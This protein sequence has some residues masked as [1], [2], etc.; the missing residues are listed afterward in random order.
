MSDDRAG[1][2]PVP[3][4]GLDPGSGW[5]VLDARDLRCPLPVI[6]VARLVRADASARGI[7]VWATDPAAAHDLPAWCRM[8]GH[9][10]AGSRAGGE[11]TAY[12][13][14]VVG[15]GG[16]DLSATEPAAAP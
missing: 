13:I 8:R 16:G 14:E 10:F 9:R 11:H 4:D 6:E 7:T 3:E 15:E 5:A 12:D 1:R 2:P